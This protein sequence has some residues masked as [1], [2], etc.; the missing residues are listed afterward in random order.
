MIIFWI[1]LI[2]TMVNGVLGVILFSR[3]FG[4]IFLVGLFVTIYMALDIGFKI[5]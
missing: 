5:T 3:I 2:S 4:L 1:V